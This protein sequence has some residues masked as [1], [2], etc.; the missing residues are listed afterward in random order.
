MIRNSNSYRLKFCSR[1]VKMNNKPLDIAMLGFAPEFELDQDGKPKGIWPDH[2]D[3]LKD[4]I[5]FT[6]VQKVGIP[7]YEEEAAMIERGDCRFGS[8]QMHIHA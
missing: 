6:P 1:K 2:I 5:E 8:P 4:Y 3:V 7:S